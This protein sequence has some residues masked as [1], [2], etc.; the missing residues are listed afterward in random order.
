VGQVG[1]ESGRHA[2]LEPGLSHG[3]QLRA[4]PR[5]VARLIPY[6]VASNELKAGISTTMILR[7]FGVRHGK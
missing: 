2:G 7:N 4:I 1:I 5:K 3:P 6:S